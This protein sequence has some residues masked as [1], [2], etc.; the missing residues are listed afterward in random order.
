MQSAT[1]D[2]V[3]CVDGG[4]NSDDD[5]IVAVKMMVMIL[6]M[7]MVVLRMMMVPFHDRRSHFSWVR[8]RLAPGI[9]HLPLRHRL[10][11]ARRSQI[12]PTSR[13]VCVREAPRASVNGFHRHLIGA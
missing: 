2:I 9:G 8:E 7:R 11:P 4:G 10:R 13:C 12:A 5:G 3:E 1:D 6:G